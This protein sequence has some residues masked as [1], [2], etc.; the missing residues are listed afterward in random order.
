[1]I[2]LLSIPS[3]FS[4]F[5]NS[6]LFFLL[7]SSR[8]LTSSLL[9]PHLTSP[10][11]PSTF[12]IHR[13]WYPTIS[14]NLQLLK[15]IER[16]NESPDRVLLLFFSHTFSPARFPFWLLLHRLPFFLLSLF[17][18]LAVSQCDHFSS[19]SAFCCTMWK[20]FGWKV[21]FSFF[22]LFSYGNLATDEWWIIKSSMVVLRLRLSS[23][24]RD[25][26]WCD[27][28]TG[29][30]RH[31]TFRLLVTPS[32]LAVKILLIS[33]W[34]ESYFVPNGSTNKTTIG[35]SF[36]LCSC[37]MFNRMFSCHARCI[38]SWELTMK[39]ITPE[40]ETVAQKCF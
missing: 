16:T 8:D 13:D 32:P 17:R 21:F 5:F 23:L 27:S 20:R 28:S 24:R 33:Q 36:F 10:P 4:W 9:P 18:L 40:S 37:E 6:V 7:Q 19:S 2:G 1:M 26:M 39:F 25:V 3:S 14:C 30:A 29:S 11:S 15:V 35:K 34:N 22:L 12:N 38:M 31:R